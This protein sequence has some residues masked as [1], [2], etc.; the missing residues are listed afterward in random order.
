MFSARMRLQ[1]VRNT[2]LAQGHCAAP[3]IVEDSAAIH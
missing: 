2:G 3:A 1:F